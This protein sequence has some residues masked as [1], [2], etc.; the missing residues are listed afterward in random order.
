MKRIV[1]IVALIAATGIMT[2]TSAQIFNLLSIANDNVNN[3]GG[4]DE[5]GFHPHP[6]RGGK[7]RHPFQVETNYDE[8]STILT[9][10]F[11]SRSNGVTVEIYRDGARITGI[12]A[13]SGTTF[14]CILRD[15]G[16]GNYTVVV[17]YGN[18][19]VGCK[20]YTVD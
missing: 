4:S 19:V 7:H 9:V 17:S 11:S 16:T 8:A 15:Y 2:D 20:N 12:I 10:S 13:N 6:H 1:L 18:T 3:N 14:S 5:K